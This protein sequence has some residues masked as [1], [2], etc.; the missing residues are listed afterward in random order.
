MLYGIFL[1]TSSLFKELENLKEAVTKPKNGSGQGQIIWSR[2]AFGWL[3]ARESEGAK[4][5]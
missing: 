5:E 1:Q 4:G 3:L 2:E